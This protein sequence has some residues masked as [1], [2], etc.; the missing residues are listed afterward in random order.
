MID[1]QRLKLERQERCMSQ[2]DLATAA[3]ITTA[4]V[5]RLESGYHQAMPRT[6]RRLAEALD[7]KPSALII[8]REER[9]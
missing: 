6:I 4:T 1:P 3:G 2:S 8:R 5:S 9:G 7:L